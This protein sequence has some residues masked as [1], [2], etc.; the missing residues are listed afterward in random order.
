MIS[1]TGKLYKAWK[2]FLYFL[3]VCNNLQLMN[4]E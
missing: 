3:I 2:K 1:Q 4:Y